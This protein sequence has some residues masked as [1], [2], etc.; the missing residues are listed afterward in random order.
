MKNTRTH[1]HSLVY[2]EKASGGGKQG[3]VHESFLAFPNNSNASSV[4]KGTSTTAAPPALPKRSRPTAAPAAPS[5]GGPPPVGRSPAGQLLLAYVFKYYTIIYFLVYF[6]VLFFLQ[7]PPPIEKIS[8]CN[9]SFC[10]WDTSSCWQITSCSC[11]C[12]ATGKNNLAFELGTI[13][14]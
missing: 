12:S 6:I 8:C 10:Y 11:W 4:P 3:I 5:S 1:T 13:I 9:G 2:N 14:I 7:G